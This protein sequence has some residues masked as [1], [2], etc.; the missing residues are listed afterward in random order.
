MIPGF[1]GDME[2]TVDDQYVCLLNGTLQYTDEEKFEM[3]LYE[4]ACGDPTG[5]SGDDGG[6]STLAYGMFI[7]AQIL[8]AIGLSCP[9]TL[10]QAHINANAAPDEATRYIGY[11]HAAGPLGMAIGFVVM[12]IFIGSG[13]WWIP[14]AFNACVMIALS[15]YCSLLPAV[16]KK[17]EASAVLNDVKELRSSLRE[18]SVRPDTKRSKKSSNKVSDMNSA[19]GTINSKRRPSS[20]GTV[21]VQEFQVVD[22]RHQCQAVV[23]APVWF[24]TALFIACE[25]FFVSALS[26]H[27][28]QLFET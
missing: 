12:G 18:M 2:E 4:A 14:F 1:L 3:A 19:T 21:T 15:I 24:F 26:S 7:L 27:G 10:G 11:L 28:P 22:F 23:T 8:H 25:A 13:S 17:H 6:G 20:L 5:G 9:Y 16:P